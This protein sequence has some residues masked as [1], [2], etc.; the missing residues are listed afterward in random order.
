MHEKP[1]AATLRQAA[2]EKVAA[3]RKEN[4]PHSGDPYYKSH[5]GYDY[6]RWADRGFGIA[7]QLLRT[8]EPEAGEAGAAYVERINALV[9]AQ[10]DEYKA[11]DE[12]ED[13]ACSGALDAAAWAIA[14]IVPAAPRT[15]PPEEIEW[16][17][18]H[19][20]LFDRE[21]PP[22]V[23]VSGRGLVAGLTEL[24]RRHLSASIGAGGERGVDHVLGLLREEVERV[25]ALAG[26]HTIA[27][28]GRNLVVR[29]E[30]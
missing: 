7:L 13:G 1:D 27:E 5:T 19:E 2:I 22:N 3:L 23:D 28:V 6:G 15:A 9:R 25:M 24:W 20:D 18:W 21:T 29:R 26:C 10:R 17:L 12:D 4:A 16:Q 11:G 14:G 30:H 8:T